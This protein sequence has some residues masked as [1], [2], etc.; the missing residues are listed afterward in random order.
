M[1]ARASGRAAP[2][3]ARSDG[4]KRARRDDILAAARAGFDAGELESFTM[5]GVAAAL[6]LAKG[7]LY[8]YVPT[9]EA[10][11]LALVDE[12]YARWFG[13]VDAG[14][15]AGRRDVPLL[16]VD[17][18]V[19]QPRFLRL[20]SLVPAVLER[21]VPSATAAEFKATLLGRA[22]ATAPLLA[23]ATGTDDAAA[24]RLLVHL[25]ASAIGLYHHAHPAPSVAAALAADEL[26][27]LRID[28]RAELDHAARALCAAATTEEHR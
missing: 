7:T 15:R 10:L 25:H 19:A 24:M 8:R 5:D 11:L 2:R 26:A 28:L 13:E 1:Q 4:D 12:E 6:G 3:R 18:L 23:A 21:N 14:L 17:A 27:A 9:R 16:L 22:R 20:L